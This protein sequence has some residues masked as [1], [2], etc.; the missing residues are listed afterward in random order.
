MM[1]LSSILIKSQYQ[2][3]RFYKIFL[4]SRLT[5]EKRGRKILK[6]F[7]KGVKGTSGGAEVA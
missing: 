3:S 2:N 6:I 1:V 4:K 7:P 5:R